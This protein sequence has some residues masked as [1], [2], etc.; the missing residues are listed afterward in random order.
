MGGRVNDDGHDCA[1]RLD[2]DERAVLARDVGGV[3]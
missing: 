3:G 1:L 2:E